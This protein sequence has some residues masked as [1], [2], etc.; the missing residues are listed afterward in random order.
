[1]FWFTSDCLPNS[2][3]RVAG[4]GDFCFYVF[5]PLGT[6]PFTVTC[7][8]ILVVTYVLVS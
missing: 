2:P 3:S 7:V 8:Y 4:M 6:C 5:V 1:M